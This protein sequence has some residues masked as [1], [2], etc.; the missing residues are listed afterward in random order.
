MRTAQV[1]EQ[2]KQAPVVPGG[3]SPILRYF[4]ILLEKGQLNHMESIELSR[5]VLQQGKK[6]LLEKWLKEGKVS[7]ASPYHVI[8]LV[9]AL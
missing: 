7:K 6:N 8:Y 2:F 5:P 3:Q 1:I 9:F 4:G